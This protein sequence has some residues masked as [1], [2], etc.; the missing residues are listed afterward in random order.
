MC[1]F[2]DL[3]ILHELII[4]WASFYEKKRNCPKTPGASTLN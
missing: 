3:Q 1:Y 4:F 2:A